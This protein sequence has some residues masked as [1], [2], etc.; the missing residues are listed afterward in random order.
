MLP[1]PRTA[2]GTFLRVVMVNDVYKLENNANVRTAIEL[3]KSKVLQHWHGEPDVPSSTP[4]S[5]TTR[6]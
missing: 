6:V 3:N 2:E 5:S 4:F 1:R